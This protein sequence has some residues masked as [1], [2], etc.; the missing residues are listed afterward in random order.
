MPDSPAD[1]IAML[2]EAAVA[3]RFDDVPSAAIEAVKRSILDAI[4]TT[5]AGSSAP[6]I[7]ETLALHRRWGGAPE[8]GVAIVGGRLPAPAAVLVNV[9]M[10]HALEIDDSHYPAIVHPTA[11]TLWAG[12]AAADLIGGVSGRD[13]LVAM[14]AGIDVMVRIALAAPRTLDNGYHTAIYSGYGAA[15]TFGRVLGLDAKT[16]AQALGIVFAQSAA[17]VQ[18][19]SDGALVK[20]LQPAFNAGAGIRAVELARV[21]VTGIARVLE[22]PFGIGTLL[23]HAPVDRAALLDGLGTRFHAAQLTTKRYP[24]SRCAHGPIEATIALMRR[25]DI[26]PERIAA[27][28]V[29]VQP[30]CHRRESAPFDPRA[31]TAQVKAQFSIDYCVAAAARWRDVFIPQIQDAAIF[32]PAVLDLARRVRIGLYRE[33]PGAT[34]YLPVRV[35]VTTV[36]GRAH[37]EIIES[38]KGSPDDPLSWDDIDRERVARCLPHAAVPAPPGRAAA[39]SAQCRDLEALSDARA[40]RRLAVFAPEPD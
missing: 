24:T 4:A 18:A 30:S 37:E 10:C 26:R 1:P 28:D 19:G 23:N 38:L 9:A 16:L 36:D 17:S 2:A 15:T 20:R 21:G 29:Q 22:G 31:G 34:P 5:A 6:G 32:D 40:L 27:I 35:T 33:R 11:P 13:L 25:H 3:V 14:V 12:L 8:A 39:L 7:A